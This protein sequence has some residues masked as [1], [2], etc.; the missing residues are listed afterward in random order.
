[1]FVCREMPRRTEIVGRIKLCILTTIMCDSLKIKGVSMGDMYCCDECG[2][3]CNVP[4]E[5]CRHIY[6]CVECHKQPEWLNAHGKI[7]A[8]TLTQRFR[9]VC[10]NRKDF[11]FT[12]EKVWETEL[13]NLE[14]VESKVFYSPNKRWVSWAKSRKFVNY[15]LSL[16]M[17][18]KKLTGLR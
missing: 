7:C 11:N 13:R 18:R 15:G 6:C 4:C 1:M 3:P 10:N 12:M 8:K 2:K 17:M 5:T 14:T 9:N 16:T